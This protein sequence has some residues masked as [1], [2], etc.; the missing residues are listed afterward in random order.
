MEL[1]SKLFNLESSPN[2]SHVVASFKT[3]HNLTNTRITCFYL[4]D[5]LMC[6]V[7]LVN[8][9]G[10][11]Q[12]WCA[13]SCGTIGRSIS[14]IHTFNSNNRS[15]T[16]NF[17]CSVFHNWA[18]DDQES[19]EYSFQYFITFFFFSF[20]SDKITSSS[21]TFGDQEALELM[22]ILAQ[23]LG[24]DC[25]FYKT[26]WELIFQRC[27]GVIVTRLNSEEEVWGSRPC[28]IIVLCSWVKTFTFSV[29]LSI[30]GYTVREE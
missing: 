20:Q 16:W 5:L 27:S 12:V 2:C 22:D 19:K 3:F 25:E 14:T 17:I 29:L 24:K 8:M 13:R 1:K 4:S 26:V 7:T 18:C 9:I 6:C 11:C 15:K 21:E 28:G 23:Y 30:Q 10:S